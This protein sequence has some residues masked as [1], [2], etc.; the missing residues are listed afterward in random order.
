MLQYMYT[1]VFYRLFDK[2][3]YGPDDP[4]QRSWSLDSADK[5]YSQAELKV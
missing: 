3:D 5:I 4:T 1:E 2:K